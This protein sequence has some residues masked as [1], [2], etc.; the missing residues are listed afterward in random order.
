MVNKTCYILHWQ[1][2]R[3]HHCWL[4]MMQ[5]LLMK[6][7]QIYRSSNEV[8]SVL[9]HLKLENLELDLTQYFM[10]QVKCSYVNIFMCITRLNRCLAHTCLLNLASNIICRDVPQW[11]AVVGTDHH[12]DK[13]RNHHSDN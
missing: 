11:L 12:S 2:S 7:G 4:T 1:S 9:I 8:T 3:V 6:T 13:I 5:C 10:L